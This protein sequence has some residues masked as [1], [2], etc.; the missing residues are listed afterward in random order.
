V[1]SGERL[2][3]LIER[4]KTRNGGG[5]TVREPR[6]RVSLKTE[7]YGRHRGQ[8]RR[9]PPTWRSWPSGKKCLRLRSGD[10]R[11]GSDKKA[12][13]PP[14]DPDKPART[15]ALPGKEETEGGGCRRATQGRRPL[16]PAAPG[17]SQRSQGSCGTAGTSARTRSKA[18][19]SLGARLCAGSAFPGSAGVLA[20]LSGSI[21]GT[22]AIPGLG[23]VGR[24]LA[25][26]ERRSGGVEVSG[27]RPSIIPASCN[28]TTSS[29][30]MTLYPR[31]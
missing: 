15:P 7:K 8:D 25:G 30:Y 19:W 4:L 14:I 5:L 31:P 28:P 27:L 2:V 12:G 9:W 16:D 1:K 22:P 3:E 21:G 29:T 20:G 11:G 6:L 10:T 13:V 24:T 23:S 26:K 17:S 18:A